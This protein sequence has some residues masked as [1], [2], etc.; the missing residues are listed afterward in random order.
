MCAWIMS[1]VLLL[2]PVAW[3]WSTFVSIWFQLIELDAMDSLPFLESFPCYRRRTIISLILIQVHLRLFATHTHSHTFLF[4]L[5]VL[6]HN[7]NNTP[8]CHVFHV[9]S[10]SA[11]SRLC[12]GNPSLSW[13]NVSLHQQTHSSLP[14]VW[15]CFYSPFTWGKKAW[16][17]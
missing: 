5:F 2:C 3:Y 7:N 14:L 10:V 9:I 8:T 15:T 17:R 13:N 1:R 11:V 12:P 6:P 16:R 4:S